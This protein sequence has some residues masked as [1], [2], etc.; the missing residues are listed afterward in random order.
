MT[1]N[2]KKI[3]KLMDIL[4]K[5]EPVS[6]KDLERKLGW[7]PRVLKEA[8]KR[9]WIKKE[10]KGREV[11]ISIRLEGLISYALPK[12]KCKLCRMPTLKELAK[13]IKRSPKEIIGA[14]YRCEW[15]SPSRKEIE[16]GDQKAKR[17]L[18]LAAVLKKE[19]WFEKE[20]PDFPE[21][22][23]LK[24]GYFTQ[25]VIE[26]AKKFSSIFPEEVGRR[27]KELE[28]EAWEREWVKA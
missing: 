9:G 2:D 27:I 15:Y 7:L 8:E 12:L 26:D 11:Y 17:R 23:D 6:R 19:K 10:K 1:E 18:N 14:A 4:I 22:Q 3:T 20:F 5:E 24:R 13:E 25:E 28:K 21:Y 16:E